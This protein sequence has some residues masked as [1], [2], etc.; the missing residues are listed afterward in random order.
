MR[1][2]LIRLLCAL[3]LVVA[4][5]QAVARGD[6]YDLG[7]TN[8]PVQNSVLTYDGTNVG[9][10]NTYLG[11]DTFY[12]AG[13]YGQDTISANIEAG[14][15]WGGPNGHQDLTLST[16]AYVG[17]GALG[18]VDRHATWVGSVLGGLNYSA[19]Q[20]GDETYLDFG[21]APATFL[22]SG[23]IATSWVA[24]PANPD[25]SIPSY[26][27]S[28]NTSQAAVYTT[29]NR[30]TNTNTA[31]NTPI[32]AQSPVLSFPGLFTDFS[33][34]ANVINCSWGFTDSTGTDPL[35]VLIDSFARQYPNTTVVV[36]AGNYPTTPTPADSVT[37]PGSGYNVI[38]VGATQTTNTVTDFTTVASFSG[39]GPQDYYDPVH[40]VVP[41]V[42][43][44][45]DIV[46]PG[47]TIVA[48]YYGGETGGNGPTLPNPTPSDLEN[49]LYSY[50]LAGTSFAAP[51]VSGAVS[52][53]NSTSV[54]IRNGY[55]YNGIVVPS[56][57]A[58]SQ[59]ALVIKAVLM[60]SAD[61]LA[62][63]NNGQAYNPALGYVVTTQAL[64]W[65]QGAGQIDFTRA[66][67]QYID[68]TGTHGTPGGTSGSVAPIGWDLG[69]LSLDAYNDYV[70]N[71]PLHAG[72]MMDATLTWFRDG[73]VDD[74]TQT[75]S[76]D[77][78]ANLYLQ[79]W[80][81]TFTTLYASSQTLYD[82]S[83]EL[84]FDLPSNGDY[85]IRVFYAS[86]M[87]GTPE[88][89]DYGLAWSDT[90]VPE[91]TSLALMAIG[92]PG[93]FLLRRRRKRTAI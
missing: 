78:M 3:G 2:S 8:E 86:Q 54:A 11:A 33:G 50:P 9:I 62:G 14:E 20:A 93:V 28:F 22:A 53:L 70:I 40:G 84:H 16:Y 73:S 65:T 57:S 31:V 1:F 49:D 37:G 25:G 43:A 72:D 47:T 82:T 71:T 39:R 75:G 56:F 91:P 13:I 29:F 80:N 64:D 21:I 88:T 27:T 89:E 46:A 60:N 55:K 18:Q 51:I 12:N 17:Q 74:A 66:F 61:K 4:G 41:G 52:L 36:A 59:N 45:V 42:R 5:Q 69:S 44:A 10:I 34:T 32:A 48:A 83:Q 7:G 30:F 76:D 35:T 92:L 58:E 15:I 77:G 26:S 90:P 68:P 23:A 85:A 79:I 81:D 63:W 6:I 67:N 87:F 38:T 24:P 19:L